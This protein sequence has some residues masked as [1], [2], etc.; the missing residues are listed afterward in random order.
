MAAGIAVNIFGHSDE[1]WA[2]AIGEQAKVYWT[3]GSKVY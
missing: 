3:L 2:D 1:V